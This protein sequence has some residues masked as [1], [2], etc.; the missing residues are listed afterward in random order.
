MNWIAAS[1]IVIGYLLVIWKIRW[2]FIVQM[3][4][5]TIYII[6]L[7]STEPSVVFVNSVFW[8]INL[9]G[10]IKWSKTVVDDQNIVVDEK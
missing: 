2:G 9:I 4:G 10:F 1:L 5:C 8:V 7:W 3:L 6:T